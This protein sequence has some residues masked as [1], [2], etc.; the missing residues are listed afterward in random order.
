MLDILKNIF[1]SSP[2]AD[3]AALIKEGATIL[4]V[5]SRSEYA[6]GHAKGS[7]NIP[8][9][10]LSGNL[11]KIKKNKP[12]IACCASGMRSSSAKAILKANGFEVY[13]A[14]AWNSLV[15]ITG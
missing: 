4:D 10:E 5:R 15:N 11:S 14:G 12:V 6:G 2:K 9:Q 1:G 8:L 13:N 7:V 3:Y